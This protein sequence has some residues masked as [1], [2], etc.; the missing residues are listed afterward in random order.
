MSVRKGSK[1]KKG[2]A[3][4]TKDKTTSAEERRRLRTEVAQHIAGLLNNPET[5]SDIAEIVSDAFLVHEDRYRGFHRN[6]SPEYI[7]DV[8]DFTREGG[9]E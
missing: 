6:A 2:R 8:L 1:T 4:E 5:P 9:A 7:L 3:T